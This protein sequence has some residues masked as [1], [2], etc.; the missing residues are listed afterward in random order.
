MRYAKY[1]CACACLLAVWMSGAVCVAQPSQSRDQRLAQALNDPAW[2]TDEEGRV[3]RV[4]FPPHNRLL[5]DYGAQTGRGHSLGHRAHLAWKTTMGLDFTAESIW[6]RLRHT[7]ADVEYT[8]GNGA[9]RLEPTALRADY[10]R[11]DT[12]S[13]IVIP[14]QRDIKIPAP[15]D[16]AVDFEL[17]SFDLREEGG[18]WTLEQIDVAEVAIP[19][20]FIRDPEYRHRL[21]IGP[22]AAYRVFPDEDAWRHELAPLTGAELLYAW[23]SKDGLH[24]V[25]LRARCVD[26]VSIGGEGDWNLGCDAR[27]RAELIVLSINDQPVS[28]PAE[29]EISEVFSDTDELAW[30]AWIGVRLSFVDN[31]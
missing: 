1:I 14:G 21:A 4:A 25:D 22:A 27:A 13:F 29:V 11:H 10:L 9:R 20:D 26:A 7:V 12:S 18:D 28:V 5:V 2:R 6:W 15:F 23:E 16:I 19:L 8:W 24:Q 3:F 31:L 30:S 17:G